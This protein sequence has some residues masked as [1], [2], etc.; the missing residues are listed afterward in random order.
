[1]KAVLQHQNFNSN[2]FLKNL[3]T[4]PRHIFNFTQISILRTNVRS[5]S[6]FLSERRVSSTRGQ[7]RTRGGRLLRAICKH[8]HTKQNN[9]K[10]WNTVKVTIKQHTTFTDQFHFGG[11]T[12]W[13]QT[14]HACC[15]SGETNLCFA[16]F[17]KADNKLLYLWHC[18]SHGSN[19]RDA[20]EQIMALPTEIVEGRKKGRKKK[21]R[22]KIIPLW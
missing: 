6:A 21:T 15:S 3:L 9:T 16:A 17:P 22:N 10:T 12:V 11:I 20:G 18:T 19:T 2:S 13:T 7:R 8:T 5:F 4:A 1:M 14:K